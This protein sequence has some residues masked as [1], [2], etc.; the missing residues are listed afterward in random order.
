MLG[1]GN[2]FGLGLPELIILLIII[3]FPAVILVLILLSRSSK[4]PKQIG[5]VSMEYCAK[6]GREIAEGSSFCPHCGEKAAGAQG[7]VHASGLLSGI[8]EGDYAVFVGRNSEKYLPKFARFREAG[9]DNFKATWHWPA[10]FVPFWWMLYRKLYGWAVLAFFL[11]FIPYVGCIA[12]IIWGLTGYYIY[13]KHAKK[14]LLEIKQLHPAAETQRAVITVTGGVGNAALI[15]GIG[16]I[17]LLLIIGILAAIAVPGYLGYQKAAR[18]RMAQSEI[19]NA[20][21]E[22]TSYFAEHPDET[23]TL[24]NLRGRGTGT[25]PDLMIEILN[26]SREG[27]SLRAKHVRGTKT[28][29]ADRD[30]K[31]TEEGSAPAPA[32]SPGQAL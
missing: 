7:G 30:C 27:L 1:G 22:A 23:I 32:P 2:M 10:F 19:L 25:A 20:C 4:R 5:E 24:D 15:T 3:G 6:C 12:S 9:I 13:Y 16:V 11:G 26:D 17:G 21:N 29:L 18:D 8:T 28:F 14:K 31:I